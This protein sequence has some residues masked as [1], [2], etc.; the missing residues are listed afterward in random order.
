MNI[1]I[2]KPACAVDAAVV[3][4]Q[5]CLARNLP[6]RKMLDICVFDISIPANE[7]F[8][9]NIRIFETCVLISKCV[10]GESALAFPMIFIDNRKVI[11]VLF[12]VV[13]FSFFI[14]IYTLALCHFYIS[15]LIKFINCIY[16][17]LEVPWKKNPKFFLLLLQEPRAKTI[18]P[19][20]APSRYPVKLFVELVL[21]Q[22][23]FLWFT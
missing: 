23:H 21:D 5:K 16:K 8:E 9:N 12:F 14:Y 22:R 4:D 13:D 11:P 19:F 7:S 18:V 1:C 6:Y 10:C 2:W 17:T 3:N 20:P 15:G